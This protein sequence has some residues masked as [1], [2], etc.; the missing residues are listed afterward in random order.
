[1]SIF[2]NRS[3][4]QLKRKLKND[5]TEAS[6]EV[7]KGLFAKVLTIIKWFLFFPILIP[8]WLFKKLFKK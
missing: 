1:M 4:G 5:A 8:I 3:R 6:I 7:S 2:N